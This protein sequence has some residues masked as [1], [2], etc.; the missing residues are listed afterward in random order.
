MHRVRHGRAH[1]HH[2]GLRAPAPAS[3]VPGRAGPAPPPPRPLGPRTRVTGPDFEALHYGLAQST[4]WSAGTLHRF[5][6]PAEL[7]AAAADPGEQA[8]ADPSVDA[9]N[10]GNG[11]NGGEAADAED[12]GTPGTFGATGSDV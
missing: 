5:R 7:A 1:D 2:R 12:L 11:G 3:G 4:D 10:A 9:G 6:T 8:K